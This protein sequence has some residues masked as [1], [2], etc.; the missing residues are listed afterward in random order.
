M[1]RA[2]VVSVLIIVIRVGIGIVIVVVLA[3]LSVLFAI[4][5]LILLV[6]PLFF[7]GQTSGREDEKGQ[8]ECYESADIPRQ[9]EGIAHVDSSE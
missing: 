4:L 8:E 6:V 5:I 9:D 2:H 7:V 3:I 1:G